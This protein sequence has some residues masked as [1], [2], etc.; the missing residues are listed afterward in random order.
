MKYPRPY[1]IVIYFTARSCRLCT[2]LSSHIASSILSSSTWSI[3]MKIMEPLIRQPIQPFSHP[4]SIQTRTRKSL[5]NSASTLLLTSWSP[6]HTWQWWA[7]SR[8]DSTYSNSS[9]RF[10]QAMVRLR[11]TKCWSLWTNAQARMWSISQLSSPCVRCFS[12]SSLLP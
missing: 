4:S 12:A 8:R 6:S 7:K 5:S 11:P 2:Y 1:D 10:P 3:S 9:G